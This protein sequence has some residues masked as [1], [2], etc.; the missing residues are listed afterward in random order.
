MFCCC[1]YRSAVRHIRHLFVH[2][3][4]RQSMPPLKQQ[5]K[6]EQINFHF[7]ILVDSRYFHFFLLLTYMFWLMWVIDIFISYTVAIYLA[8][9]KKKLTLQL[10]AVISFNQNNLETEI[11]LLH[12]S[13]KY[14][15]YESSI[16]TLCSSSVSSSVKRMLL[17]NSYLI[18][19]TCF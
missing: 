3:R 13:Y 19:V 11:T 16:N 5:R 9:L 8:S 2:E 12:L 7:F 17:L 15:Y 14:L 6:S 4:R 1:C 18:V 10:I